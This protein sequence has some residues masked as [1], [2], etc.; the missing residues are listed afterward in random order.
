MAAHDS[1][2][3][4]RPKTDFCPSK[5]DST[6]YKPELNACTWTGATAASEPVTPVTPSTPAKPVAETEQVAVVAPKLTTEQALEILAGAP[7]G[8]GMYMGDEIWIVSDY[9][10][11]LEI[12]EQFDGALI[13]T[14]R[15]LAVAIASGSDYRKELHEAK[16]AG[17]FMD[18][19]AG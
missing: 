15:D 16:K 6:T 10:R 11:A 3:V 17:F 9:A 2:A 8:G 13:Y 1:F 5:I 4:I 19:R 18:S 14:H 12:M 7:E